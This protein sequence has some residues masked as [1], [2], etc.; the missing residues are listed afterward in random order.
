[1]EGMTQRDIEEH[2]SLEY[3]ERQALQCYEAYERLRDA[4]MVSAAQ[5]AWRDTYLY[6]ERAA[7]LRDPEHEV[8]PEPSA[9]WG[10][11]DLALLREEWAKAP[12]W[13]QLDAPIQLL[14]E[15]Q[16]EAA[17]WHV[18]RELEPYRHHGRARRAVPP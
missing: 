13:L 14:P 12:P 15:D 17:R 4:G 2:Y 7:L 11:A 8:R 5:A 10:E 16:R 9:E 18:A 3:N 6:Q 1:M